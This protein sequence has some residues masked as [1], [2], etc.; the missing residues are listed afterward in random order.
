MGFS[1]SD[2]SDAAKS[3][4]KVTIAPVLAGTEKI[5]GISQLDQLRMGAADGGLS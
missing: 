5:T 2:I 1:F 3:I 4:A